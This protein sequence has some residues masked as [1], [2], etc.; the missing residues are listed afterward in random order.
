[1][2][3]LLTHPLLLALIVYVILYFLGR[4]VPP[5]REFFGFNCGLVRIPFLTLEQWLSA[6]QRKA[7]TIRPGLATIMRL[8]A[9]SVA[10]VGC[11]AEV[12]TSIDAS[13]ATFGGEGGDT[14]F[15]PQGIA[16]P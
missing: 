6:F 8:L 2:Q 9:G 14:S 15:L 13:V 10:L 16:A 3:F 11:V 1:M 5:I 4:Y 7:D 12:Y